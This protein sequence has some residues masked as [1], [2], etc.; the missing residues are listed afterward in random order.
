MHRPTDSNLEP[1][2][3]KVAVDARRYPLL[4]FPPFCNGIGYYSSFSLLP[5]IVST[6][7]SHCTGVTKRPSIGMQTCFWDLEDV[8]L[9]SCLHSFTP[10][11]FTDFKTPYF[12]YGK[13]D[14]P[15][16]S[17]ITPYA[18]VH[19]VKNSSEILQIFH[20]LHH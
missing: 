11:P 17:K 15:N 14:S 1:R 20:K 2:L 8:F 3:R 13:R 10:R 7:P 19:P 18:A 16:L 12:Y 4:T 9:G 5:K 6:C